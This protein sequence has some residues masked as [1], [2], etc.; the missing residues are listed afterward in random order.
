MDQVARRRT[1]AGLQNGRAGPYAPKLCGGG[2]VGRRP[3]NAKCLIYLVYL[4]SQ[5]KKKF[6]VAFGGDLA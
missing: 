1:P 2:A 5:K 3:I 6:G 4:K